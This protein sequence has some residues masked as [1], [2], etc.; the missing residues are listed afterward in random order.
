MTPTNEQ[1][2]LTLERIGERLF[3]HT[4]IFIHGNRISFEFDK[5]MH[6]NHAFHSAKLSRL[7]IKYLMESNML[8]VEDKND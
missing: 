6:P 2:E 1:Q 7:A 5:D 8:L 4:D 3:I